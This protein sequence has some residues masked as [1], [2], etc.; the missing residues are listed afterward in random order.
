VEFDL[1]NIT[2][3][4]IDLS[5]FDPQAIWQQFHSDGWPMALV[6]CGIFF[7]AAAVVY[8][9]TKKLLLRMLNRLSDKTSIRWDDILLQERVFHVL[10]FIPPL[11]LVRHGLEVLPQWGE[12]LASFVRGAGIFVITVVFID[13]LLS[14]VNAIYRRYPI[15]RRRPIKG[16]IQLVKIFI[17]AL[18]FVTAAALL[19]GRSPWTLL[20]GIGAVTAVLLLIFRD[21]ILSVV[22]SVQIAAN[23][24]LSVG[25]WVQMDQYDADGEVIDIAL[26]TVK[27]QN[28]DKTIVAVPTHKFLDESFKNWRGMKEAG[29]RRIKRPLYVDQAS[30]RFLSPEDRA[31]LSAIQLL[32]P[33]I[34]ERTEEIVNWNA[35]HG[36]SE[37]NPL[38]G[39]RMTNLGTFRAYIAAYLRNRPDIRQDMTFLVRHLAPTSKGLPLEVYVFTTTTAWAEYESIQ[40][41]IFDH[42]LAAAEEFDLRVFQDPAGAD[43]HQAISDLAEQ[44]ET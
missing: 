28:W 25:D 23:E 19:L 37:D 15:S 44:G 2:P 43:L 32:Q 6:L 14:A 8:I 34:R 30:I 13:R 27:I 9:V 12:E 35:L 41:D 29:G 33:Y 21:T 4:D 40:A 42:L 10:A 16:Y 31:R 7:V 5:K 22:A 1:N 38:N 26:H 18:A 17:H 36:A 24:T 11:I 39:R 20:S 3:P